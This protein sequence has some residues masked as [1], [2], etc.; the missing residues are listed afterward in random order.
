MNSTGG[1][2][3]VARSD[4]VANP[5]NE[6]KNTDK[7]IR[8]SKIV[9]KKK[10]FDSLERDSGLI[11][12]FG[13]GQKLSFNIIDLPKWENIAQKDYCDSYLR[14]NFQATCNRLF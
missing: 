11:F 4:S 1:G 3:G 14:A 7:M 8:E 6:E 12:V 10:G 13:I 5:A 2:G 9:R